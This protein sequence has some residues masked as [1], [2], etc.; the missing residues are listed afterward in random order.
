MWSSL[1]IPKNTEKSYQKQDPESVHKSTIL[2][3][4]SNNIGKKDDKLDSKVVF[5]NFKGSKPSK[6][7]RK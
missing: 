1:V 7:F 5:S 6:N 3:S 2:S 4:K